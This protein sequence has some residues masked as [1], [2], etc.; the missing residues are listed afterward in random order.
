MG[1]S[2]GGTGGNG[3]AGGSG[4]GLVSNIANLGPLGDPDENGVR[5]PEGFTSRVVAQSGQPPVAGGS[6]AWHG[7]PDGGA[8][9]PTMDGGW[10]YVSNCELDS[11]AG[12]VGALR[13]SASGE[14]VDAYSILQSTSRNCAG[15]PTPWGTWLSCEETST[16]QVFECDPL[17]RMASQ[18]RPALGVF[19]HEAV[20]VD[21]NLER[22]YLTEDQG[23]GRLY[24]FVPSAYPDLSAGTLEVFQ[25]TNGIEGPGV[26]LPVP[27]PSGSSTPT[28]QQVPE[29]TPFAGGEGIWFH[30][31]VVYFT[32]K[33]D[34]RV[35][36]LDTTTDELTLIYDEATSPTPILSGVDN[37]VVSDGGDVLVA[38]DGGDLEIVA[39]TPDGQVL[40]V[41]QLV[42]HDSSE[43]TGPAFDP[44]RQRLYFSSQRGTLGFSGAGMTFEVTGPFFV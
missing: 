38:E 9:F 37:V 15:G 29:S 39:L 12:G 10:I 41:I 24:R 22:L 27:D 6:Y 33:G 8:V 13:F 34:N 43:I 7:A 3:G 5:L 21:P 23:N 14:V 30:E 36:A 16:G 31:G 20:T 44:S 18:A 25:V 40:P 1:G 2:G 32:T 26:W 11:G 4:P 35:W 28:R 17:G 42:G 19:Q